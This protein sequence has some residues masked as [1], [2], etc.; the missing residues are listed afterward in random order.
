MARTKQ[1][2]RKENQIPNL[3]EDVNAAKSYSRQRN[4]SNQSEKS[5]QPE[6]EMA[7]IRCSKNKKNKLA[8]VTPPYRPPCHRKY[9]N[10]GI[11]RG[12]TPSEVAFFIREPRDPGGESSESST[13]SSPVISATGSDEEEVA[14]HEKIP[15]GSEYADYDD[16]NDGKGGYGGN[17]DDEDEDGNDGN[18]GGSG[19]EEGDE[20]D[21]NG[22]EIND[23]GSGEEEEEVEEDEAQP[24][25]KEKVPIAPSARYITPSICSLL[26]LAMGKPEVNLKTAAKFYLD[27]IARS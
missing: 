18:V 6:K 25:P 21:G 5:N 13:L 1:T 11:L 23:G 17:D 7:P 19:D 8:M 16:G 22:N 2:A 20:D 10:D 12:K 24:Q 27:M 4:K 3:V 9:L 14:E 26:V 15:L